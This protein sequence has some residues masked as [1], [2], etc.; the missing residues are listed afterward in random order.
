MPIVDE[1][2]GPIRRVATRSIRAATVRQRTVSRDRE[3]AEPLADARGSDQ[4]D[5]GPNDVA[6]IFGSQYVP[7][8]AAL[9]EEAIRQ[10]LRAGYE[11]L[12]IVGFSSLRKSLSPVEPV[13]PAATRR[14][15]QDGGWHPSYDSCRVMLYLLTR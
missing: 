3:G 1:S 5:D 8:T 14:L 11:H 9:V 4:A 2:G 12:L 10:A 13:L 15:S 6:A 7:V